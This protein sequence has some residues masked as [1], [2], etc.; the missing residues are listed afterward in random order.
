MERNREEIKNI[1][2]E[3]IRIKED[4]KKASLRKIEEKR[5]L[6]FIREV[7]KIYIFILLIIILLYFYIIVNN[8]KYKI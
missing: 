1:K 2:S 7:I 3:A 4:I 5:K 8:Y 6:D